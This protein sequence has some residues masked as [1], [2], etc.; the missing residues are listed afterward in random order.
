[1][2]WPGRLLLLVAVTALCLLTGATLVSGAR[3]VL[4]ADALDVTG[5]LALPPW[6]DELTRH[7]VVA[8]PAHA[9]L[10]TT[11]ET[12]D[13]SPAATATQW[14]KAAAH[15]DSEAEIDGAAQGISAAVARDGGSRALHLVCKHKE[16]GNATQVQAVER[17][18][19][20]CSRWTPEVALEATASAREVRAGDSIRIMAF[21]TSATDFSGLVDVEI[22]DADAVK[23]TQWVFADQQLVAGRRHSYAVTWEI[24]SDLPA[25]EYDVKLGVFHPGWT[26]LHGWKRLAATVSVTP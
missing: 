6:L 18:Q 25:G 23:V 26:A 5:A 22:H 24:P 7:G 14:L 21:V 19:L 8:F 15:A 11:L 20:S 16:I 9:A 17:S 4:D 2:I 12:L 13:L 10:A 1:M 3:S